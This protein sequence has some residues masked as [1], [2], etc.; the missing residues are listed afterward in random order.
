MGENWQFWLVVLMVAVAALYSVWYALPHRY[1]QRLGW[2]NRRLK[3]SSGCNSCEQCG[4]CASATLKKPS[5]SQLAGE[6][7]IHV[8]RKS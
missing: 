1:R 7:P 4:K 3:R 8:W 2:L 5:E 6:T